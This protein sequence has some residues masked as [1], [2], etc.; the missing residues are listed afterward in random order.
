MET[1][2]NWRSSKGINMRDLQ[3]VIHESL[4][5]QLFE[6]DYTKMYEYMDKL[7]KD[8]PDWVIY[9]VTGR[10]KSQRIGNSSHIRF[11]PFT[12]LSNAFT[13]LNKFK[14]YQLLMSGRKY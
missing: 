2:T 14:L 1:V 11:I 3:L 9:F 5:C 10:G 8:H 7:V 6:D 12:S 4:L 13:E